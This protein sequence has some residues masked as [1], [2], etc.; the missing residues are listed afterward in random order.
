LTLEEFAGEAI[1]ESENARYWLNLNSTPTRR[2]LPKA[3]R[4]Y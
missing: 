3:P 1:R 4:F 2:H